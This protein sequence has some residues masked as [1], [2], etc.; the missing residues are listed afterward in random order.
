MDRTLFLVLALVFSSVAS[1]ARADLAYQFNVTTAFAASDP[2]PNLINS[3]AWSGDTGYLRVQNA[4]PGDYAGILEIVANSSYAGDLSFTLLD[5]SIPAGGSVSVG[6]P[7]DSSTVGGFN[8]FTGSTNPSVPGTF[9]PGI[10]MYMEGSVSD[11]PGDGAIKIAMQDLDAV[12]GVTL[13]DPNGLQTYS[14]V[15]QG[16]DPFGLYNGDAWEL[17]LGQG[18]VTLSGI[19]MP[20]PGPR[21][22]F[23][24]MLFV[25]ALIHMNGI[26]KTRGLGQILAGKPGSEPPHV[27]VHPPFDP[28]RLRG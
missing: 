12:T 3:N 20:E 27:P 1:A 19:A 17:N 15:L 6:M 21:P 11:G 2:F 22:V 9:R 23:A 28:I 26:G 13:T 24:L 14:F 16:G 25:L 7:F 5:V 10:I 18:H 4:G 8:S